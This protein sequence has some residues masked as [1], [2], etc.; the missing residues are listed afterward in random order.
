[1]IRE[2]LTLT[3]YE[4]FFIFGQV[5]YRPDPIESDFLPMHYVIL[6][7]IYHGKQQ[8]ED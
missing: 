6:K 2:F 4:S 5:M 3:A 8:A 7:N 1:M